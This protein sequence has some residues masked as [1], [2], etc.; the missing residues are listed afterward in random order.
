MT[1]VAL[2]STRAK[3]KGK[4]WD[5]RRYEREMKKQEQMKLS[6]FMCFKCHEVGYLANGCPNEEKLK[7]KKKML[8]HVKCF[9]C[10]TWDHLTSMCPTKK[11]VKQQVKSQPR[12]QVEQEETPQDQIKINHEDGGN[13]MKKKKKKRRSGMARH[14]K[15]DQ[16]A[17]MMSKNQDEKKVHAH[18]KCFKCRIW[19][20]LTSMYPTK[21]LVKHQVMPQP[22]PQAEQEEKL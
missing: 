13:L 20:H 5:K 9:K 17:K 21:E 19:G 14:Q 8:K 22:K 10:R 2:A 7:L 1:R 15:L 3:I 12:P 4:R 18:I 16:D 11:V 6:H